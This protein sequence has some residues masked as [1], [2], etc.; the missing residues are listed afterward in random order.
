MEPANTELVLELVIEY[1]SAETRLRL[2]ET[3]SSNAHLARLGGLIDRVSIRAATRALYLWRRNLRNFRNLRKR[4]HVHSWQRGRVRN[5][6][7]PVPFNPFY[8]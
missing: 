4:A 2:R 8:P 3:H 1:A 7:T 5:D 6:E